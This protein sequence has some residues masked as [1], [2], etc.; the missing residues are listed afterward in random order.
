MEHAVSRFKHE[1]RFLVRLYS[2]VN[3]KKLVGAVYMSPVC[4]NETLAGLKIKKRK[5][6]Y[7]H[8]FDMNVIFMLYSTNFRLKTTLCAI[9]LW[10]IT[11]CAEEYLFVLNKV[12]MLARAYA[13][14]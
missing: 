6:D 11:Y 3:S 1:T 12:S 13:F 14:T 8:R 2:S 5:H 4:Q 9:L 10:Q 7:A